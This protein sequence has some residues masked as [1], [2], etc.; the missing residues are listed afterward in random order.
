MISGIR[1]PEFSV[2]HRPEAG[3]VPVVEPIA[4][5]AVGGMA[6]RRNGTTG[7]VGPSPPSS[8]GG[9]RRKRR[10]VRFV[11]VMKR[12]LLTPRW[13]A[14][15]LLM[16]AIATAC[17]V[18]GW[19]QFQRYREGGGS[20]QN[21]G[22]TLNWP[23]FGAFGAYLWWRLLR[24]AA[25]PGTQETQAGGR[26]EEESARPETA[27]AEPARVEAARAEPAQGG[28]EPADGTAPDAPTGSPTPPPA[29]VRVPAQAEAPDRGGARGEAQRPAPD[30]EDDPEL[31]AYN[32]YLAALNE[33]TRR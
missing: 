32:R 13:I 33:R 22:Y 14:F 19:W 17:M 21:L 15:T 16:A 31:A 3:F 23:L 26:T 30:D 29:G 5:T 12:L 11:D 10:G 25:R 28:T 27:S 20:F 2:V 18:L 8:G 9:I 7:G 4:E 24:D 1:A 6:A